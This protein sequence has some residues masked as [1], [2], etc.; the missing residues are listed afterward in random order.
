[1][2]NQTSQI[3]V[4]TFFIVFMSSHIRFLLGV[5]QH[6]Q[7]TLDCH[8]YCT[9]YIHT[10]YWCGCLAVGVGLPLLTPG[11]VQSQ[12]STNSDSDPDSSS[13]CS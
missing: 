1:M 3:K 5:R 6:G 7:Y 9:W 8:C 10:G 2:I 4:S 11:T 12:T 13:L